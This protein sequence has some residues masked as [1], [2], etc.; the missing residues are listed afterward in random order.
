MTFGIL[1]LFIFI[2][3]EVFLQIDK[4]HHIPQNKLTAKQSDNLL[5]Y[6]IIHFTEKEN[7]KSIIMDNTIKASQRKPMY[8]EE[9]NMTWFFSIPKMID[10]DY[11]EKCYNYIKKKRPLVD[12]CIHVYD[13]KESELGSF[14]FQPFNEYIVHDGDVSN[15]MNIY[16]LSNGKWVR[17][18]NL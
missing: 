1:C 7:A 3:L 13:I 15:K 8:D 10:S 6:G 5:K 14:L 18:D 2:P 12:V 16:I 4:R 17:V 9:E 11:I